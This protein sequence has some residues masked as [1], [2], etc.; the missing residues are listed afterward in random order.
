L[1]GKRPLSENIQ[2]AINYLTAE[3]AENA[4]KLALWAG[5]ILGLAGLGLYYEQKNVYAQ[6]RYHKLQTI[7]MEMLAFADGVDVAEL[8]PLRSTVLSSPTPFAVADCAV[9][10][11][12]GR[13]ALIKRADNG[14]WAMPGGALEVG[15]TAAAGA[16]REFHEETGM[17]CEV[18]GLA[19]VFDNRLWG[20][21]SRHHSYQ[22]VFMGKLVDGADMGNGSH[23]HE[24]LDVAWFAED[25]LPLAEMDANHVGRVPV[26]FDVRRGEKRPFFDNGV[27]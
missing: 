11:E 17:V 3:G 25:D 2:A 26:V 13:L 8:E 9:F 19:G 18:T 16:A 21:N 10:D 20:S 22:F 12:N 15:E 1:D 5:E 7:G 24:V 14:L 4:E 23:K 6:E 27:R